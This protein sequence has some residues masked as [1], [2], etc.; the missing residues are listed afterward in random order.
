MGGKEAKTLTRRREERGRDDE[1]DLR[2]DIR[3]VPI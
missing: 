3:P 1:T 2:Q